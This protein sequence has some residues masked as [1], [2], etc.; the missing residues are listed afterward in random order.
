MD[1]A[2]PFGFP[3][4]TAVYLA[5]YVV[6]LVIH[7]IFMNYVLA[8]TGYLAVVSIVSRG[9]LLE[10]ATS[11]ILRDWMPFA[12]SATITAAIA[13]LLFVQVLYKKAFYTANLLLVHRWM[14]M[15]PILV[16]GFYLLY[17]LKAQKARHSSRFVRV[18]AACGAFFCFHFT[19]WSWTENHML[20]LDPGAWVAHYASGSLIYFNPEIVPRLLLWCSGAVP[21]LC[22]L[23]TW[24]LLSFSQSA[25]EAAIRRLAIMAISGLSA[26]AGCACWYL[27]WMGPDLRTALQRPIA[28]PYLWVAVMGALVQGVIWLSALTRRHLSA[29]MRWL[30]SGAVLATILGVSIARE[31]IRLARVNLAELTSNVAHE[32]RQGMLVFLALLAVNI[33]VIAWCLRSVARTVQARGGESWTDMRAPAAAQHANDDPTGQPPRNS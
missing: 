13:P 26:A 30:L 28:A 14:I 2:F 7:V 21:T 11:N 29:A 5:L 22:L 25:Q 31:T 33:G 23:L 18:V 27:A 24:Q 19:A 10:D 3:A 8:G 15:L 32:Q 16:V 20:S 6:T 9:E 4:S 17:V 1:T 12:L